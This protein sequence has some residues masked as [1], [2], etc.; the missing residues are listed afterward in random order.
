MKRGFTL[1]ELLATIIIMLFILTI[2][3]PLIKNRVD[4]ARER[5]L[6]NLIKNIEN[7]AE[8][9]VLD[10][11][12]SFN[13]L[14]NFGYMNIKLETLVQG[15]YIDENLVNPVTKESLYY[16]D[17]VYVT[18][19]YLNKLEVIYDINQKNKPK[20]TLNGTL[21]LR[22][23]KG[24]TYT[25]LGAIAIDKN[26][27][28]ISSSIVIKG[29]VD[30]NVEGVYEIKYSVNDSIVLTRYVIVTDDVPI[31][32]LEKPTLTSN[33]PN[34]Y[35]ETRKGVAIT[36]PIVTAHDNVDGTIN[37]IPYTSNNVDINNT[38]TYY[39]K[40]DYVDSSGNKADT[41]TIKVVVKP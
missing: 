9:Y 28:D 14:D 5:S 27:N 23:K 7:A 33:I 37:N 13:E 30:T 41:L 35:I 17:V 11:R 21:N 4:N 29:N 36:M 8:K 3:I 25:E 10:N 26:G 6:D 39:I 16:D 20:I 19:N 40:Y 2:T 34:N 22:I 38:G 18:L 24:S 31:E 1:M 32:D 15:K 12:N